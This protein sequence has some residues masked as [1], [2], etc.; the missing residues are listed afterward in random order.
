[1]IDGMKCVERSTKKK[2]SEFLMGVEP[3]T[4]QTL[5]AIGCSKPLN[6]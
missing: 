3:T 5:V 1:M 2:N 4:L 6:Y